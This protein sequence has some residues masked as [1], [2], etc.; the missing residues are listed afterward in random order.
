[1]DALI[2]EKNYK[3]L[4]SL[5]MA[6]ES[7]A[8]FLGEIPNNVDN[9][10][11]TPIISEDYYTVYVTDILV[12]GKT[13]GVSQYYYNYGGAIVD[14]GTTELLLPSQAYNAIQASLL[15]M[16]TNVN[17]V[18][19]CNIDTDNT[20]FNQ[21]CISMTEEQ[22]NQYPS[23]TIVLNGGVYLTI[24]PSSWIVQGYCQIPSLYAIALESIPYAYGTILGDTVLKNRLT[25]F[26]REVRIKILLISK[27][28]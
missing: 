15:S 9:I 6:E 16:C 11:Y 2:V 4:F 8:L 23:L 19:T 14:S 25:V 24:P 7:G 22:V 27:Q 5:C 28:Y 12:D 13:I 10:V 18:G 20:L 26:D 21:K 3:D 17:L 1:M